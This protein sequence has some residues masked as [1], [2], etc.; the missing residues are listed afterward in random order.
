MQIHALRTGN[1]LVKSAFLSSPV[2]AGGLVPYLAGVFVDRR[3]VT[4]PI[5]AWAIEHSEGVIVVDTGENAAAKGHFVTQSR[6]D[7][8]PE[9]EIGAQ[10]SRLGIRPREV[11]KVV[12]T[13]LHGDHI[14]GLKDLPGVQVWVNRREYEPLASP[15]A[16]PLAKLGIHVPEGFAPTLIDFEPDSTLPFGA[17]FPLTRDGKVF[18]VPTPGHTAGHMSVIVEDGDTSVFLAGDVTYFEHTLIEQRLEGPVMD[19]AGGR[20]TLRQ[21]LAYVQAQPT[22]YL[23]AHDPESPRRLAERQTV[24]SGQPVGLR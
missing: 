9:E 12:L 4:L 22:V 19:A 24:S 10:L 23:P 14:D 13:H 7:I 20:E 6:F 11:A 2:A 5:M 15:N 18:A 16:G 1:V 21:V 17:R 8:T 3:R